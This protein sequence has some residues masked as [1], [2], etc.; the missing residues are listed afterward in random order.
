MV[1]TRSGLATAK[2]TSMNW[3]NTVRERYFPEV[4]RLEH[5]NSERKNAYKSRLM[6]SPMNKRALDT[7]VL[8][9]RNEDAGAAMMKNAARRIEQIPIPDENKKRYLN[10]LGRVVQPAQINGIIADAEG[11]QRKIGEF[12]NQQTAAKRKINTLNLT[13]ENRITLRN[14][15]NRLNY[16]ESGVTN[17]IRMIMKNAANNASS[18]PNA[19]N[20]IDK[21]TMLNE[22][23]KTNYK[24]QV[25]EARSAAN[26]RRVL[27]NAKSASRRAGM[28]R[29][30]SAVGASISSAVK[31]TKNSGTSVRRF[32]FDGVKAGYAMFPKTNYTL[33]Q[34]VETFIEVLCIV[35][36]LKYKG[37]K[38]EE[39]I[40]KVIDYVSG[41][42]PALSPSKMTIEQK[43]MRVA[44]SFNRVGKAVMSDIWFMGGGESASLAAH[45]ISYALTWSVAMGMLLRIAELNTPDKFNVIK[46]LHTSVDT[47]FKYSGTV[48]PAVIAQQVWKPEY[49]ISMTF[50]VTYKYFGSIIAAK[51]ANLQMNQMKGGYIWNYAIQA[52]MDFIN[53]RV[54]S[55]R[56]GVGLYYITKYFLLASVDRKMMPNSLVAKSVNLL[57]RGVEKVPQIAA[58]IAETPLAQK[59]RSTLTLRPINTA[60]GQEGTP[61]RPFNSPARTR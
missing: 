45:Y 18:K 4:N 24:N 25:N 32:L 13:N 52:A 51:T 46:A 7:L 49:F 53:S 43:K 55:T 26:I 6:N 57:D 59:I 16:T 35:I 31:K 20:V 40:Q 12:R 37:D 48:I 42:V 27:Q 39:Y 29:A 33:A 15:L 60:T 38:T 8:A 9:A 2:R 10:R 47:I 14:R 19:K 5:L 30:Y 11:L 56:A 54:F 23:Q 41:E 1:K 17:K 58:A 22:N 50:G 21:M 61:L 44:A 3:E 36:T 28:K 34:I